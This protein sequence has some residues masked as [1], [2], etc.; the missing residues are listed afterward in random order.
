VANASHELRTPLARQRTLIEVAL[1]DPHP[2]VE[3]LQAN[4]RRLLAA[5]QQQERLVEALL[6]LARSEQGLD[7]LEVV[8]LADVVRDILSVDLR[9]RAGP[10]VDAAAGPAPVHGDRRLLERLIANLLDNALRYNHPSGRVDIRTGIDAG[11]DHATLTIANTGPTIRPADVGRLLEPF[12]RLDGDRRASAEGT[13]LGLS[14]VR[15]IA[16]AHGAVVAISARA[17]GGLIAEVRFPRAVTEPQPPVSHPED[18][19]WASDH[20]PPDNDHETAAGRRPREARDDR[21][22]R[23]ASPRDR[24]RPRVRR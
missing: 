10:H 9:T 16:T 14:I 5:G 22:R 21:G 12:Q 15:A 6:T 18:Q 8:D 4:N 3:S 19:P 2:T 20:P 24:G 1:M 13:G 11:V 17:E 7:Q 23:P